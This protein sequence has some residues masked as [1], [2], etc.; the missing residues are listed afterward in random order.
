MKHFCIFEITQPFK[1]GK[2]F[3]STFIDDYGEDYTS[4]DLMCQSMNNFREPN[5]PVLFVVRCLEQNEY[6]QIENYN[7]F[8]TA[9]MI[10]TTLQKL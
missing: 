5:E 6:D 3:K 10:T 7:P 9:I 1:H 8:I 4:A 2:V